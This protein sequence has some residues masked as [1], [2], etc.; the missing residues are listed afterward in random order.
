MKEFKIEITEFLS[1]I[2]EVKANNVDEAIEKVKIMY[3]EETIILDSNNF[4]NKEI[5]MVNNE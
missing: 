2:V 1:K 5:K 3:D 4:V